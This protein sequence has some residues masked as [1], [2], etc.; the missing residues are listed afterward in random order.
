MIH[1]T[2][3]AGQSRV[4]FFTTKAMEFAEILRTRPFV[5]APRDVRDIH[6]LALM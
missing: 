4:W 6:S 5:V 2:S 3:D 1:L